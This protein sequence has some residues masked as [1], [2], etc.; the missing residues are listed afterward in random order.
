VAEK[1]D[2]DQKTEKPTPR[3]KKEA[4]QN[5]QIAKSPELSGWALVL[6]ATFLVPFTFDRVYESMQDTT[7]R[8]QDVA[9][10]ATPQKASETMGHALLG[11]GTAI[12][13]FMVV[14]A[15]LALVIMLAQVGFIFTAKPLK[16][17]GERINPLAGIKRLFTVRSLWETGKALIKLIII[18]VVAVPM[19]V[20]IAQDLVGGQQFTVGTILPYLAEQIVSLVRMVAMIALGLGMADYV[21]QRK[22]TNKMMMMTKQE[23]KQEMKNSEGDPHVKGKIRALQRA[24]SRNRMMAAL[25]DAN[26]VIMNPTHYAVALRY[27]PAEGAPRVI[28]KGSDGLALR[29]RDRA[30]QLEVPVVE[31]PPLARALFAACELDQEIPV[32]LFNA[33]AKVLAFVQRLGG[34][35][36]LAGV[37]VVPGLTLAA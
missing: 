12:L 24:N 11:M 13:P 16:P 1:P 7:S 34:R 26:V 8:I 17:K 27:H 35:A 10:D 9:Q 23:M 36:S 5:G 14:M 25:G 2:K 22:S 30:Q 19:V 6:A 29:I 37:F 20:G 28:A 32:E 18:S 3:R 31:A 4:R 33:V 15:V 21:Y